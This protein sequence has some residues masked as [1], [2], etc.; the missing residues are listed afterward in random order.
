MSETVF[1]S[2]ESKFEGFKQKK[3]DEQRKLGNKLARI[4]IVDEGMS[5]PAFAKHLGLTVDTYKHIE[6]GNVSVS[7]VK[8]LLCRKA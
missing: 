1:D 6:F 3:I 5:I 7:H 8:R 4:R 2:L